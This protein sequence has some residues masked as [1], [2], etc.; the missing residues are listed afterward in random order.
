MRHTLKLLLALLL[1]NAALTFQNRW[2]TVGVRW[3]LEGSLDL[4]V[5]LLVLAALIAWRGTLGRVL[6]WGL[7]GIYILLVAGRY[8]EVTAPALMGR[9]LNLYWDSQHLP[10]VLAMFA[11]RLSSSQILLGSLALA[12][13]LMGIVAAL[14]WAL[15]TV[16]A[17][18]AVPLERRVISSLAA[19]LLTLYGAG[20]LSM[21]LPT[22]Y[23]FALPV[24]VLLVEQVRLTLAATV[25]R[26][27][28]GMDAAPLL[29][30]SDLGRLQGG[31]L[32]VIFWESYGAL[33]FDDPGFAVPLAADFAA[34][35][36][37][38]T[39]AGWGIASARVE[40]TTFGGGSWLAHSSLLSGVRIADQGDYQ[41]LLTTDRPALTHRFAAAGYRTV[42]IMP[43]L[44]FPW[45]EGRFYGFAEIYQPEQLAYHGPA[46]GWWAIPDQYS[47]YRIHRTEV[48]AARRAPLLVFFPTINS[49]IPF[50]PL[51][52]YQPDWRDF[53][54]IAEPAGITM[55]EESL[56]GPELAAAYVRSVR[57]NLAVISGYLRQYAPPNVL[58]L[59]LGD[60]QPPAVVGGRD[61]PWQVPAHLFSRDPALLARFIAA[62]F[63][64]GIRLGPTALGGIERLGP[65]LLNTLD[66]RH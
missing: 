10:N 38:L 59:V 41:H 46:Y 43:G 37:E 36:Q 17:A 42:A 53:D 18:L 31:D 6:R 58:F 4:I 15:N 28:T 64:P 22:E 32:F 49:H 39:A 65:L 33:T 48:E 63:Q 51:P 24:S 55:A 47:L 3:T 56:D 20:R 1:L 27:H 34:L 29:P 21:W 52:P 5:L 60:H 13:L 14:R 50:A 40:S 26:N 2:P 23:G 9:A 66:T 45:P 16:V 30:V 25:F 12:A 57:Y 54:A 19:I 11:A 44:K 7:Q 61:L 35:E 8:V 62:G